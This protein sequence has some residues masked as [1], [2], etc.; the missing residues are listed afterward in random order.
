MPMY[1]Y[2][3]TC[4]Q[5][6]DQRRRSSERHDPLICECGKK[7]KLAIVGTHLAPDRKTEGK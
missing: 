4:G 5:Q 2:H 3:C 6:R 7:M 1:R